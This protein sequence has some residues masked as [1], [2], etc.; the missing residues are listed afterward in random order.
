MVSI[1][2]PWLNHSKQQT[3]A[4]FFIQCLSWMPDCVSGEE[5]PYREGEV[6]KAHKDATPV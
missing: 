4:F 2:M 3:D 6:T 1:Q 5:V